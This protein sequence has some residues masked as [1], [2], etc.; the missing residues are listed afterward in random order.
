MD[1]FLESIIE[2]AIVLK[3]SN[4]IRKLV[5]GC[6]LPTNSKFNK[7]RTNIENSRNIIIH[8]LFK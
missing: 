5:F 6:F 4:M 1:G 7:K 3:Y 8:E 2:N